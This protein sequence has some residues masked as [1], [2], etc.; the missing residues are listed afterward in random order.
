MSSIGLFPVCL[1]IKDD[2]LLIKK[3]YFI[4]SSLVTSIHYMLMNGVFKSVL[5]S[6]IRFA[7]I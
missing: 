6:W 4:N 2:K 7:L 5:G 3:G 1:K